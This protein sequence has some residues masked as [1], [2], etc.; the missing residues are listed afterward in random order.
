[1]REEA[2]SPIRATT[3]SRVMSFETAEAASE[4]SP[5]SSSDSSTRGLPRT[6]PA[7]LISATASIAPFF[8]EIAKVAV[9]PVRAPK[10]PT[11]MP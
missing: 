7:A 9:G 6:P 10:K 3:W 4:A 8:P 2:F 5:R 1:V 11:L